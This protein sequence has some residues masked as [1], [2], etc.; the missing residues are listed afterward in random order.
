MERELKENGRPPPFHIASLLSTSPPP[1]K[2]DESCA[3]TAHHK[4]VQGHSGSGEV[5]GG[6]VDYSYPCQCWDAGKHVLPDA[7]AAVRHFVVNGN[8]PCSSLFTHLPVCS[9]SWSTFFDTYTTSFQARHAAVLSISQWVSSRL[10]PCNLTPSLLTQ[11]TILPQPI[12]SAT[13]PQMSL[14]SNLRFLLLWGNRRAS[15]PLLKC[16]FVALEP[17]TQPNNSRRWKRFSPKRSTLTLTTVCRLHVK[18]A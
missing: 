3:V 10:S 4:P 14:P 12:M 8:V 15:P 17:R 9:Y 5:L 2:G 18:S 1:V 13:R 6:S 11:A 16:L 7:Q